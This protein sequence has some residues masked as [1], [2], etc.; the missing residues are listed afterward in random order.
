MSQPLI[1]LLAIVLA[2]S[3]C[4][5]A[6]QETS[7]VFGNARQA[8]ARMY[9]VKLERGLHHSKGTVSLEAGIV[10]IRDSSK[11]VVLAIPDEHLLDVVVTKQGREL[12]YVNMSAA[13][14]ACDDAR[15][16]AVMLGTALAWDAVVGI[17]SL[18][19]HSRNVLTIT[20]S[21]DDDVHSETL[22]LSRRDANKLAA[23][24]H[25]RQVLH[26]PAAAMPQ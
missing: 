1:G 22:Q 7:L 3:T 18:F 16:A 15:E 5:A 6:P 20:Y 23:Q 13:F 19:H 17:A 9:R 2:A 24:L 12:P 26:A 14:Q 4:A 10:T 8:G 25:E 11:A 21:Q